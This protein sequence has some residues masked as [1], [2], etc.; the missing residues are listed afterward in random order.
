MSI[1][2]SSISRARRGFLRGSAGVLLL[3]GAGA[4]VLSAC[5][6]ASDSGAAPEAPHMTSIENFRDMAG[7]GDGY[8]TADGRRLRQGVFYRSGALN[9]NDADMFAMQRLSLYTIHDL[10]TLS[11]ATLAPDRVPAGASRETHE[12]API[13]VSAANPDDA[14]AARAWMIDR[15]R[16]MIAD[17]LARV[18]FGA[19][20]KRLAHKAGPQVVHGATGKD[21][22][23]WA[24]AL[25]LAIADVPLDVIIQDY[26]MTN[27]VAEAQIAVRMSAHAA[28]LGV[29][30]AVVAPLHQAQ[31]TTIE[32]AFD[33]LQKRFGTLNEYL[34]RGLSL[35]DD[36]IAMLRAKLVR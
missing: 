11:E 34:V 29:P 14:A 30:L 7:T 25:I 28:R 5:G 1:T 9:A 35:G 19:L 33:E 8:P 21:R 24:A 36:D 6:G 3:G 12:I 2:S 32:A 16:E 20:L 23:G 17:P 4:S 13:D 22:T 26:L 10:R 15:Q 18:Q 27:V 31:S